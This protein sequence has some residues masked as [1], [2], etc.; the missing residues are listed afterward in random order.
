MLNK[1]R[2]NS[3]EKINANTFKE[4]SVGFKEVEKEDLQQKV[5]GGARAKFYRKE[6]AAVKK[7]AGW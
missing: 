5:I 2:M 3:K 6:R 7:I 4:I 1:L